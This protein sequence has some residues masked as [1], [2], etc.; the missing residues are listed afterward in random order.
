MIRDLE[1]KALELQE[2]LKKDLA[3]IE[4]GVVT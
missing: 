4:L 3:E 2:R 1:N